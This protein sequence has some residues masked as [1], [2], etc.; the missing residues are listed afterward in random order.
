[1]DHFFL[2]IAIQLLDLVQLTAGFLLVVA[3]CFGEKGARRF[4]SKFMLVVFTFQ[5]LFVILFHEGWSLKV[6][7]GVMLMLSF[8]ALIVAKRRN[9]GL[10]NPGVSS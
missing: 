7:A 8:V 6:F 10:L 5:C 1:M 2:S 3:L 9:A 4:W